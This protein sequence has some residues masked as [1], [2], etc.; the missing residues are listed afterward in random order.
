MSG[1]RLAATAV[2]MALTA[3]CASAPAAEQAMDGDALPGTVLVEVE[4]NRMAYPTA[5][6]HLHE[7][8][9]TDRFLGSV[10]TGD[11]EVF[12]VQ[13][14]APGM[15]RLVA[16]TTDGRRLTSRPFFMTSS[17]VRWNLQT[18]MVQPLRAD[19]E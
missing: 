4:H 6:I 7:E 17:G 15:H 10:L 11:V 14:P 2:M 9:G 1:F 8:V 12:E 13:S 16:V 19:G 3:A 18:N 5:T